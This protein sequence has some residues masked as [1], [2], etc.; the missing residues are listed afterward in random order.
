[1]RKLLV[2]MF[3]F[4]TI[5]LF[6]QLESMPYILDMVHNNPGEE[7]YTT[8]YNSP[9]YLKSQ[10]FNGAVTHWH[11]NC[12]IN[13]DNYEKGL[14]PLD[15]DERKWI[16]KHAKEVELK[17]QEF[18]SCG[19]N[20]YPFTDFLVFPKS[21]WSKYGPELK[22]NTSTIGKSK[23]N[24]PDIRSAIT[25][26]LLRAQIEGIFDR[27]PELD[28][29]TLRFGETYL[30][31]TPYHLGNSP[32]RSGEGEIEDHILLI[33]ILRE[34]ICVKR[35]K[36]LF[37][38]T[39]DFG[40]KFHN[41]PRFYLDVTNKVEPHP[42][43]I[44]S[45]KYQQDDYHRM[46][47]FNPTLGIGRHQQ[48]V[49]SQS[50]MEAYGKGAHPYYVAKGVIDGW[51]ETKYIITRSHRQTDELNPKD[52][53]RG[54]SD[55]LGSGLIKGVMTWSHGGGWRG[56]YIKN[57]IW[58]DLNTY[59]VSQWAINPEMT[60]EELFGRFMNGINIK[61]KNADIFRQIALLSI[62]GVRKGHC[63]SYV[64]NSVW[65]T[66]DQ[67]FTVSYNK[68]IIKQILDGKLTDKVL[69]EKK[70]SVAIWLQIEALSKQ[71]DIQNKEL[72][73]AIRVSCTYGRIKYQLIEQMW[74]M[75]IDYALICKGDMIP[76][77]DIKH[78]IHTY[79]QIW[80]EWRNLYNQ[81]DN[82]ATIYTDLAF[83]D[84]Y[85]GS[86]RELVDNLTLYIKKNEKAN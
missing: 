14:V 46:T 43:L 52:A 44:F 45:V 78:S 80:D 57:E 61:G 4:R 22:G 32:I 16:E 30:H 10:G 3:F 84:K 59:V 24:K 27:F 66:R 25:Q 62:E 17:L 51:P 6:G 77:N 85:K 28:G 73:S 36:K 8:K 15:S 9:S 69:S 42:N 60:E 33:N 40:Y 11:I 56:P 39:W 70:E 81:N 38:R 41:N 21:I 29:I 12:A 48:I 82:C 74:R 19:V 7:P 5:V 53:P 1:M 76:K 13:Y 54:V 68:E 58:T 35:N 79:N 75:M 65:W 63:N 47:P 83:M 37:Y 50:R 2:M 34:E 18:E 64:E 20:T 31:D 71:L 49:E 26:K 72:E 23:K 67:Y 55:V 86:V